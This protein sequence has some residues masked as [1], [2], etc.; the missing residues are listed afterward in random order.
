[1]Y[2]QKKFGVAEEPH[3]STERRLSTKA[4]P[5]QTSRLQAL[6]VPA[7]GNAVSYDKTHLT[8]GKHVLRKT[9]AKDKVHSTWEQT[10]PSTP[11]DSH[12]LKKHFL[13]QRQ[14]WAPMLP[15]SLSTLNIEQW[16]LYLLYQVT[17]FFNNLFVLFL[18]QNTNL[19]LSFL[20]LKLKKK[21]P[22]H[23]LPHNTENKTEHH[24][25]IITRSGNVKKKKTNDNSLKH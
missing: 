23:N 21:K 22:N 25:R 7:W 14:L 20:T 24:A 10:I 12:K 5:F 16:V 15:Q 17:R 3:F 2:L 6:L 13:L 9:T 11:R 1:M 8:L 18:A 4:A 19:S